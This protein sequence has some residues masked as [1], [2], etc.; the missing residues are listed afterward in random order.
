MPLHFICLHV[1]HLFDLR[2]PIPKQVS[3][4]A[5]QTDRLADLKKTKV[6]DENDECVFF[7]TGFWKLI[8]ST[9]AIRDHPVA[10]F[11]RKVVISF[12]SNFG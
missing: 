3:F 4:I 5:D 8:K 6:E 11:F 10:D 9:D 1:C 12:I 2:G 7:E